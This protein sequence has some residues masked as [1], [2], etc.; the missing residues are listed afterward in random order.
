MKKTISVF[1]SLA[2]LLSAAFAFGVIGTAKNNT[3][4]NWQVTGGDWQIAEDGS[5]E[6]VTND[7]ANIINYNIALVDPAVTLTGDYE[8]TLEMNAMASGASSMVNINSAKKDCYSGFLLQLGPYG[9]V[10]YDIDANITVAPQ[11]A[12]ADTMAGLKYEDNRGNLAFNEV[13]IVKK[14]GTVS[15]YIN[16]KENYVNHTLV[17]ATHDGTLV[18]GLES[19]GALDCAFRNVVVKIGGNEY[20]YFT[21]VEVEDTS[22]DSGKPI[23]SVSNGESGGCGNNG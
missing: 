5:L 2:L 21:V 17:N 23:V 9:A 11:F 4:E 6:V 15:V 3:I 20:K 10:Y 22:S 19:N 7:K 8:I 13:K 16:G 1:I 14:D 18:L 12:G